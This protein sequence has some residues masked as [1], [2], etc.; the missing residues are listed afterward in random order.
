[1]IAPAPLSSM[2]R[3]TPRLRSA[4]SIAR[5]AATVMTPA[6]M[7]SA[8]ITR[9][10]FARSFTRVAADQRWSVTREVF[11][12]DSDGQGEAHYRVDAQGHV[13]RF[14]AYSTVIAEDDRTDRVIAK[15]WDITA[16][17]V[18]GD[19]SPARLADLRREVPKQERGRAD[20]STLI[21]TRAN[22]SSR[23]FDYVVNQ[24]AAGQQPSIDV[25][26][27]STYLLRSTAFYGNGK[28]GLAD[29]DGYDSDHPLA[30]PYRAQMLCAWLL[31]ELSY[32]L[33]EHCARLRSDRAVT[34]D[35]DWH[36]FFGLGNATGLGMVP[37]IINHPQVLDAWVAVRELPLAYALT[38]ESDHRSPRTRRML[39]LLTRA[40][41]YF[42][43]RTAL[44]TSPYLPYPAVAEGLQ[45]VLDVANEYQRHGTIDGSPTNRVSLA[46]HEHAA[47]AGLEVRQVVDTVLVECHEELD[48]EVESLLR[49]QEYSVPTLAQRCSTLLARLEKDYAWVRDIDFQDPDRS[50]FFWYS[51]A[52]NQEPRR[53]VRGMTPGEE[54]E[55][56]IGIARAVHQL[57]IDLADFDGQASLAEFLLAHPWHRGSIDRVQ[58]LAGIS[59]AEARVNLLDRAFLPLDLQRFQ[60][61]IYGMENFSPQ[62][63]DWLR[64]TLFGGAPRAADV[65]AGVDGDWLF[66]LKPDKATS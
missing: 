53:G 31:R 57:I 47:K 52:D 46:L 17:L 51:S 10:S 28:W 18:E 14:I 20:A 36:R 64:V 63:T 32:D 16:A 66:T 6:E 21:W 2:M 55:H 33:V 39:Q 45:S 25:L 13:F 59:Y 7:G 19:L 50:H 11:D 37:Y 44:D 9:H 23:F 61:A 65:T 60:L 26:G 43:E 38:Q 62:S 56:P 15:S 30:V 3:P 54:V 5:P 42:A 49:C 40:H 27:D 34:L 8:R 22:R 35:G 29:F 48:A 12:I 24:L 41:A 1:M 58:G 4:Q